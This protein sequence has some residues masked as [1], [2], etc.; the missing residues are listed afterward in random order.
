MKRIW[1]RLVGLINNFKIRKKLI[2]LFVFCVLLPMFATDGVILY[3]VY[4]NDDRHSRRC[5]MDQD[6]RG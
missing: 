2:I 6:G 5:C 3:T 4:H 1:N